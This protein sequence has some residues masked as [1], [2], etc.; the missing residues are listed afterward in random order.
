MNKANKKNIRHSIGAFISKCELLE[1]LTHDVAAVKV[2]SKTILQ[3]HVRIHE[4]QA[5]KSAPRIPNETH[6][7]DPFVK[8]K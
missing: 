7:K 8:L 6:T 5:Q 2:G 3:N 4:I 1:H